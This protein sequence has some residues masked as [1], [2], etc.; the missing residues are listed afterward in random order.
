MLNQYAKLLYFDW[1]KITIQSRGSIPT[2]AYF[3]VHFKIQR[4]ALVQKKYK[5]R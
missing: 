3:Q 1:N 5:K 2:K 4:A